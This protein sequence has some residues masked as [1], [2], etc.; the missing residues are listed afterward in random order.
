[1]VIIQIEEVQFSFHQIRVSDEALNLKLNS[2]V[3]KNLVF[4]G[5]RKQM[6]AATIFEMVKKI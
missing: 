6:C 3:V 4:D 1:M 2:D 5:I